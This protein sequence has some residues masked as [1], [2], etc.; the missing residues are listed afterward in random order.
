VIVSG[1][2]LVNELHDQLRGIGIEGGRDVLISGN[3]IVNGWVRKGGEGD[4]SVIGN[5]FTSDLPV[6]HG[7]VSIH[8][9]AEQ[10]IVKDNVMRFTGGKGDV[11]EPRQVLPGG[12]DEALAV[13][14]DE[15]LQVAQ[16]AIFNAVSPKSPKLFL[17]EGNVIQGWRDAIQLTAAEREGDPL[18]FIVRGN[19]L[20]GAIRITGLPQ[21]YR[22]VVTDNLDLTTLAPIQPVIEAEEPARAK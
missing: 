5:E 15:A 12:K 19:S 10:V 18:R 8:T 14:K 20:D 17:I 21:F 6:A 3:R 1:N 13:Q 11:T 16:P 22:S 4:V 2:L 9:G 7:I